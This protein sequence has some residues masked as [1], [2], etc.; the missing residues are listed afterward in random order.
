M[1]IEERLSA[2]FRATNCAFTRKKRSRAPRTVIIEYDR[3]RVTIKHEAV[4]RYYRQRR[5]RKGRFAEGKVRL[6]PPRSAT[7][8]KVK[9][10]LFAANYA[11]LETFIPWPRHAGH[12]RLVESLAKHH[13]V[14]RA[15]GFRWLR[16]PHIRKLIHEIRQM[17]FAEREKGGPLTF[18]IGR[19]WRGEVA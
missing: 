19:H 10:I 6:S 17:E 3:G 16:A 18:A 15:T 12:G 7:N 8:M 2:P 9:A 11:G 13:G 4:T 1:H 14:S 5:D